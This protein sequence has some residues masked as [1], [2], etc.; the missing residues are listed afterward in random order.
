MAFIAIFLFGYASEAAES[1]VKLLENLLSIT[2][3]DM[4]SDFYQEFTDGS[5]VYNAL[6]FVFASTCTAV[7]MWLFFTSFTAQIASI[8]IDNVSHLIKGEDENE[9]DN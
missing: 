3:G 9:E 7:A 1:I 4:I 6:S 5:R 8:Y 2:F